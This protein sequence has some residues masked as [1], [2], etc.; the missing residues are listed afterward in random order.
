MTNNEVYV[1][2]ILGLAGY[3]VTS[4]LIRFFKKESDWTKNQSKDDP[5]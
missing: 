5:K 1:V 2:I 4:V 3:L